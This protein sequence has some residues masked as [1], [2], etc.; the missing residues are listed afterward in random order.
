MAVLFQLIFVILLQIHCPC[1]CH[2]LVNYIAD[3]I[4]ISKLIYRQQVSHLLPCLLTIPSTTCGVIPIICT[5][6]T[7]RVT[8]QVRHD[9][10]I[11]FYL[12]RIL[13]ERF[14]MSAFLCWL[15][16]ASSNQ[17]LFRYSF[18]NEIVDCNKSLRCI[19]F[20]A[21]IITHRHSLGWRS[22][23]RSTTHQ[24]LLFDALGGR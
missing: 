10:F 12:H 19:R 16:R 23:K 15:I 6:E 13:P 18:L 21:Y 17:A 4:I 3:G 9:I 8:K 2:S 5:S 7:F 11:S 1:Q 24:N 20:T 14:H 22:N